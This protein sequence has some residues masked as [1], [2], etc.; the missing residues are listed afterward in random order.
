VNEWLLGLLIVG[1]LAVFVPILCE[2][3]VRMS[4]RHFRAD[5]Q[6]ERVL[7]RRRFRRAFWDGFTSLGRL[8]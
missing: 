7:I 1:G 4:A 8:R 6:A 2:I 5:T 3:S